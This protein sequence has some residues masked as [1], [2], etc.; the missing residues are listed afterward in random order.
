MTSKETLENL[1]FL[2]FLLTSLKRLF[3][4]TAT[5]IAWF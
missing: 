5:F 4:G 3:W 2:L 1:F